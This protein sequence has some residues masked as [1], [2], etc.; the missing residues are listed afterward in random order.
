MWL[1]ASDA[2]QVGVTLYVAFTLKPEERA[3]QSGSTL[4]SLTVD[5][6]Q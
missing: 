4:Q 6:G 3:A 5:G 2:V 1:T